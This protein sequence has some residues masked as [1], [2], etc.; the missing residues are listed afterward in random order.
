MLYENLEAKGTVSV[1][2]TLLIS[3]QTDIPIVKMSTEPSNVQHVFLS[4]RFAGTE[5]LL[6]VAL[7]LTCLALYA[8]NT[9]IKTR[10]VLKPGS[11]YVVFLGDDHANGGT[12]TNEWIN[13]QTYE[14][15]CTL[16]MQYEYPYCQFQVLLGGVD[17]TAYETMELELEYTGTGT[18]GDSVRISLRNKS[19]IY[20]QGMPANELKPNEIEVPASYL[21][22]PYTIRMADFNVP[23][24]WL[25]QYHIPPQN[26]HAEY[27]D[28]I[29]LEI[30][31]GSGTP[32]GEYHFKLHSL[33]WEGNRIPREQ[34][35]LG[36]I[37]AWLAIVF[38]ILVFRVL[39][40]KSAINE[41]YARAQNLQQLNRILDIKSRHFEKMARTDSLTGVSNRAG[42]SDVLVREIRS[43][44]E[45]G[46][47][48][49]LI[50]L[51]IDH[52]KP[53]NDNHGHDYGDEVLISVARTL[54][55]TLRTSDAVARWGGEEFL[56]VCPNT[57]LENGRAL[58]EKLREHVKSQSATGKTPLTA[59]FGVATL[60]NE[61]IGQLI[62]R[63]DEALYRAK[64]N[65]RDRV[66]ISEG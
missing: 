19:P 36:I 27:S 2:K 1:A 8:G 6:F 25:R 17:L 51:D 3:G 32:P 5:K 30:V 33:T 61:S 22:G 38:A 28:V 18:P 35:Y 4:R 12:S 65:G 7:V 62:K 11:P 13:E 29:F 14:W 45:T 59:S 56:L 39:R 46:H 34:W 40:L 26:S 15:R 55:E 20:S 50:M 47:P 9:L 31:T 53:I 54:V 21:N 37:I 41:H 44:I 66:E 52:F 60:G 49:T 48:L 58:A 57:S 16:R 42:I 10:L 24:W 23:D 43:H 64:Q 63:V